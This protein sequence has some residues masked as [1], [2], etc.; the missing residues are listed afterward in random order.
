M[1]SGI[2]MCPF[3]F[4]FTNEGHN[5]TLGVSVLAYREPTGSRRFILFISFSGADVAA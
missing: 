1:N 2:C 5:G 3:S 4:L